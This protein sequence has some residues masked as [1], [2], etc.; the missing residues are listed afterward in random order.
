LPFVDPNE[1]R[2]RT[3]AGFPLRADA[4][5]WGLCWLMFAS[6]VLNYMDRQT[7]ALVRPQIRQAFA[8]TTD[9]EFGWIIAVFGMVYALL[10]VP[11]GF[12]VDRWDLRWSYA[13]AVIWWSLAAMSTAAVPGLGFFIACRALLGV[14]ESFNWPCALRVT[15]RILPPAERSLGNG[16]FNSGAAV[17]AV[18]TPLFVTHLALAY[19]WRAAFLIPGAA[20]LVWVAAWLWLVKGRQRALLAYRSPPAAFRREIQGTEPARPTA[21]RRIGYLI[22]LI[23]S[24]AIGLAAIRYGPLAVWLGIAV[25]MIGP[26]LAA[27][28][29]PQNR[30]AGAD[31][32]ASLAEVVRKRRFWIMALVSITINIC[33]HFL[34]NWVPTYFKDERHLD[35]AS[36]NSLSAV[37]FLAA[38]LGNLGGGW[39]VRRLAE[40]GLSPTRARQAVLVVCMILIQ[41]GIAVGLARDNASAV[42]LVSIMAA[43]TAAFM[44]NYFAFA[45]EVSPQHTGLIVGYLGGLGNLFVAGF[46]PFAGA[47][48][49]LTG[50]FSLVFWLVALLPWLGLGALF[51][52][53]RETDGLAQAE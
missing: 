31:W 15:A 19:G 2:D 3:N 39:L 48:K 42:I 16:I 10:Q 44:A 53:W 27:A 29:L 9:Q 24:I 49:D 35:Y 46:Q 37:P 45:Q 22:I 33:W 21:V 28:V 12:L 32:S 6:T 20:G 13:G 52:G 38:A 47:V 30:L 40:L 25:L 36:S 23:A 7:I 17:G 50:S 8:I 51:V 1:T 43:G 41:A 34:V 14:G 5:A 26:L 4:Q 18:V 11:A